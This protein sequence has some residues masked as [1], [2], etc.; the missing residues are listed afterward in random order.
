MIILIE[1]FET[2]AKTNKIVEEAIA[3][4]ARSKWKDCE[5]M[6]ILVIIYTVISLLTAITVGSVTIANVYA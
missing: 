3:A 1:F 6:C 4:L 2:T 5:R